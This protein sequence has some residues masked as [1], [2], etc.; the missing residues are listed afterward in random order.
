VLEALAFAHSRR[1]K[2]GKA[3]EIVHRDVAPGNVLA[4][5]LGEVKL[6]DFGIAKA[7][8]RVSRTEVGIV[9]GN[10]QFM[11][12]EQARGESVDARSDIFSAGLVLYY[13]LTGQMLYEGQTT[14]NRL[15]R[16]AVGPVTAQFSQIGT[17][18]PEIA[19]IL[20]RA[21]A[22]TPAGRYA[23]ADEFKR[24]LAPHAGTRR[25]LAALMDEVF[26]PAARRDL[27]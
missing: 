1:D 15:M 9:K 16:A 24:A 8:D 23:T 13:C 22:Q 4:S 2:E 5:Y 12:P 6:T 11:S 14:V 19:E 3:M 17:M 21:L 7:E 20:R 18:A 25:D 10:A 26:P 27:R